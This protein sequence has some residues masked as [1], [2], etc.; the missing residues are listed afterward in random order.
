MS[1]KNEVEGRAMKKI[2]RWIGVGLLL[3]GATGCFGDATTV[4]KEEVLTE[5]Q[6]HEHADLV[7]MDDYLALLDRV[8]R[9]EAELGG[10]VADG[11]ATAG[12]DDSYLDAVRDEVVDARGGASSLSQRLEGIEGDGGSLG[13][14]VERLL[15]EVG[16]TPT[17]L[18]ADGLEESRLDVLSDELTSGTT[19]NRLD[20]LDGGS[21]YAPPAP[22]TSLGAAVDANTGSIAANSGLISSN[23]GA[24]SANGSLIAANTG[25]LSTHSGLIAANDSQIS[26]NTNQLA[27]N[28]GLI[29]T[30]S[31]QIS[32][33]FGLITANGV[34]IAANAADI[35]DAFDEIAGTADTVSNSRLDVLDAMGTPPGM[36]TYTSQSVLLIDSDLALSVPGTAPDGAS[37]PNV[38]AAMAWLD[39]YS[40]AS[41]VL[42]D[43]NVSGSVQEPATLQLRHRD[44][45]R[46]RIVDFT[47]T[48]ELRF[49]QGGAGV[50]VS[51]GRSGGTIDGLDLA[52]DGADYGLDVRQGGTL[53]VDSSS[54]PVTISGFASHGAVVHLG[55]Y[56]QADETTFSSNGGAGFAAYRGGVGTCIDCTASGNGSYGLNAI[57]HSFVDADGAT[58]D[59]NAGGLASL[60]GS[61]MRC[62]GCSLT[63]NALDGALVQWGST[64]EASTAAAENNQGRGFYVRYGSAADLAGVTADGNT[65]TGI[66]ASEAS[67]VSA[68]LAGADGNLGRGAAASWNSYLSASQSTLENNGLEGLSCSVGAAAYAANS[69]FLNNGGYGVV[70]NDAAIIQY[71]GSTN[72]GNVSGTVN[73]PTAN[74]DPAYQR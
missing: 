1:S 54:D 19:A 70:F 68:S 58:S 61:T 18:A 41:D 2:T 53:V 52:G 6:N 72:T 26:A 60:A 46:V 67:A 4:A 49:A 23:S 21:P 37:L 73:G 62:E 69:S 59:N 3:S 39:R 38:G 17:S 25:Q 12:F 47:G 42:V 27:T 71:S 51:Q 31:G 24:I 45:D 20:A 11:G 48:S 5:V 10:E 43:I 14:D 40:I 34:S 66:E 16:G 7:P 22:F 30:N 33:N 36:A 35:A 65:S 9:L 32:A 63:G 28:S 15:I 50:L 57:R 64:L 55:G 13:A 44:G 29:S 74:P 8:E 56:L